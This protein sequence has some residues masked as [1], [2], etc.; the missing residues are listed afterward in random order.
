M[1][2]RRPPVP[3]A[4]RDASPT[5]EAGSVFIEALVA[6]AIVAMILVATLRVVADGAAHARA[7]EDRRLALLLARSQLAAVGSQ[8]PLE[9]GE[10]GGSAGALLWTVRIDP[11]S[12]PTGDQSAASS[13]GDLWQVRVAVRRRETRRDLVVLDTVRLAPHAG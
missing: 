2:K 10:N 4:P 3:S 12:D 5:S 6:T 9:A 11:Y 7:V 1:T 13:A 8:T